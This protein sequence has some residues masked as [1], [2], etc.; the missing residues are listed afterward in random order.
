MIVCMMYDIFKHAP[1]I[2]PPIIP[3]AITSVTPSVTPR[4]KTTIFYPLRI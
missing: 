2:M 4:K 3:S 1:V